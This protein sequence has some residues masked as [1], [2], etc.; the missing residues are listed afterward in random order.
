MKVPFHPDQILF[1]DNHI[2]IINKK[3]SQIVQG[4]KTGD[5]PLSDEI[6]SYLKKRF[7]KPGE[8]YLGVVHRL[9][10]PVSGVVIFARTSKA[11][12]RLNRMLH[13]KMIQK[14]YWAVVSKPPPQPEGHLKHFMV[15]DE[16]NNKSF[17][18]DREKKRSKPAELKYRHLLSGDHYHLLEI[19]LLTGRHHQIRVQLAKIGCIIKGDIKYGSYRPNHDASIHL[20]AIRVEF[21]HP[22][23]GKPVRIEAPVP[24]DKLW[25]YF[26]S[27]IC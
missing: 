24:K 4:D 11:L 3:S 13:D 20:H 9:D 7:D 2:I 17:A 23:S 27:G 6:K 10:R 25:E 8:V 19:E 21:N 12:G 16:K 22:V 18:F 15:K 14:T 5:I 1:E 26:R